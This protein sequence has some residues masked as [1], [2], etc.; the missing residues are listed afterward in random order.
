M[1]SIAKCVLAVSEPVSVVQQ[2]YSEVSTT[3]DNIL[4]RPT[5]THFSSEPECD[6]GDEMRSAYSIEQSTKLPQHQKNLI[7]APFHVPQQYGI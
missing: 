3:D 7:A 2:V 1:C 4:G 6:V 5:E